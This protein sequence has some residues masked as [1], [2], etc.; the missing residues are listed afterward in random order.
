MATS[1]I[2]E[3]SAEFSLVPALKSILHREYDFVTP[4]FPWLN[5]EGGNLS[6]ALHRDDS[7]RLLALFARRPKLNDAD[8]RSLYMT[9]N[10]EL[11]AFAE[12]SEENGIPVIAGCPRASNFWELGNAEGF[13]WFRLGCRTF[14]QYLISIDDL[15]RRFS[16]SLLDKSG[17]LKL[18][19]ESGSVQ[20][21]HGFRDFLYES[22]Q[23][24]STGF[25]GAQYK[26][27]YF[28]MK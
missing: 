26:P 11:E 5:R 18:V 23:T 12:L 6:M 28:L 10:S 7:F 24:F 4:V 16:S 15:G 21:I 3:H 13:I 2:C 8:S 25:F 19:R 9:I 14:D 27:V 20:N 17:V 22:R 1:Y